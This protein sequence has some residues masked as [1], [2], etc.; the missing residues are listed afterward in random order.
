M[1]QG[2][3]SSFPLSLVFVFSYFLVTVEK[4]GSGSLC[5]ATP[6][7]IRVDSFKHLHFVQKNSENY[8]PRLP[9]KSLLRGELGEVMSQRPTKFGNAVARNQLTNWDVDSSGAVSPKLAW[10]G[11][12]PHYGTARLHA[13]YCPFLFHLAYL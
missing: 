5:L 4:N 12:L 11:W 8:F 1:M 2:S 10:E 7:S 9:R 6:N 3:R 13:Y